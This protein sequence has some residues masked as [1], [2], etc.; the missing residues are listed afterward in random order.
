ME[1][2][3]VSI[4]IPAYNV[5]NFIED[6]INSIFKQTYKNFEIIIVN[7]CSKDNSVKVINNLI[8][9]YKNIKLI[10]LKKNNG[11]P[12]VPRNEGVKVAKGKYLCFIDADD[13]W[14]DTKLADQVKFM[15][16]KDCAFSYTSYQFADANCVPNGKI[17]HAQEVI[18]YKQALKKQIIW[19]SAVM[20]DLTKIDKELIMM[21][22][23]K[24]VEDTATWWKVL[25]NG[26][27][28][29]GLDKVLSYYRRTEGSLSSNKIKPLKNLWRVYRK[30]EKLNIFKASYY[31]IAKNVNAVLR[32]V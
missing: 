11:F 27:K 3:L 22:E 25:R 23:I 18:E 12:A 32:R 28:A 1:K 5:E 29:Y 13:K 31:F 20:F 6:S 14:V 7:D 17:V 21:P 15:K 16:K 30:E 19:T 8:K 24:Y 9:K 26:Y 2:D 4:I 10:N